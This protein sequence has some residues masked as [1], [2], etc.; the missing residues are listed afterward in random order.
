V[1][2][3]NWAHNSLIQLTLLG[4]CQLQQ[5]VNVHHYEVSAAVEATLLTD[6]L[7]NTQAGALADDWIANLK[8]TWLGCHTSDYF[9]DSVNAQVLER[10]GTYNHKLTAQE[11]PLS[12]GNQGTL[13]SAADDM[14][15]AA[16][17]RWRTPIAGKSHRGRSYIGP[18]ADSEVNAGLL[19]VDITTPLQAYLT[20]F[21]NR[22][23]GTGAVYTSGSMTI[24][25]KPYNTGEYQYV[26]RVGGVLTVVTPPDYAGN[27]TFI[28]AAAI[29]PRAR[30]QRRREIGVGS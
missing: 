12:T 13:A 8:T 18:L 10:P 23:T 30:V 5:I 3:G 25:S 14:T 1:V 20:A 27:S 9:L 19:T 21:L 15:T 7:A 2:H 22:Y 17:A 11:R 29:D 4:R 24:Y 28:T 16:V 26:K 6:T